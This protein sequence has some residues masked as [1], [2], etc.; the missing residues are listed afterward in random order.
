[1]E[2]FL[3]WF[4][5]LAVAMVMTGGGVALFKGRIILLRDAGSS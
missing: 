1:M 2:E 5:Q 4:G 3:R